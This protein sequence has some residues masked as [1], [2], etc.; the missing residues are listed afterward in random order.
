MAP[1]TPVSDNEQDRQE[2][3]LIRQLISD[4]DALKLAAEASAE[5][6]GLKHEDAIDFEDIGDDDLAEDEDEI[7]ANN[8]F[9]TTQ[10]QENSDNGFNTFG[11]DTDDTTLNAA[12][13][14]DDLFGDA[15]LSPEVE[16]TRL[17]KNG[18]SFEFEGDDSLGEPIGPIQDDDDA[19]FGGDGDEEMLDAP[20]D[21]DNDPD[22]LAGFSKEEREAFQLQRRLFAQAGGVLAMGGTQSLDFFNEAPQ[23]QEEALAQMWPQFQKDEIPRFSELMPFKKAHWIGKKPTRLPKPVQATK[24]K[25]DIAADQEKHFKLSIGPRKRKYDN[26]EEDGLVRI[27]QPELT[28]E[29]D[30]FDDESDF[31]ND[32]IGGVSWQELQTICADWTLLDD[33]DASDFELLDEAD[34]NL[35]SNSYAPGKRRRLSD[36]TSQTQ[37]I[38]NAARMADQSFDNYDR[39]LNKVAKKVVL[40]INDPNLLLV[41]V[42]FDVVPKKAVARTNVKEGQAVPTKELLKRYNI[43]NDGAYEKLKQNHQ[44][45]IRSTLGNLS[46]NHSMPALRLTYPFYKTNLNR[47]ERR[48][49]HRPITTFRKREPITFHDLKFT[50][51]KHQRNKDAK[52]LFATSKDLSLAETSHVLLLE[53]SEEAPTI[54]SNF[55]MNSRL[56]SYYRKR[57]EDDE[58]RPK[59]SLG[60]VSTLMPND[61]SPLTQFGE[62]Q[63]GEIRPTIYNGLFKA[64]VFEH[65]AKAG[66]FLMIRSGTG[67]ET[68]KWHIRPIDNLMVVGQQFPSID[69]PPPGGRKVTT[70]SK[71]R[72]K[73]ISYRLMKRNGPSNGVNISKV[74][75]HVAESSDM[76]NRQKMKDF[77]SFNKET[78]EWEMQGK[79]TVPDEDVIRSYITPEDVC[80]LESMQVGEQRLEDEGYGLE[81]DEALN[82]DEEMKEN[83]AIEEQLAP[84]STSKSFL[85]AASNKAMLQLY[86]EGDPTGRGEAFSFLKISMKGGFRAPNQSIEDTLDA[87]K[88]QESSGHNYNVQKQQEQYRETID[89]IWAAQIRSLS[90]QVEHD[91]P[92]QDPDEEPES[93]RRSM[94]RDRR[95]SFLR[96]PEDETASAWSSASQSSKVCRIVRRERDSTGHIIESVEVI[97]DP[98]VWKRYVDIKNRQRRDK[99]DI[100]NIRPED[101]PELA[102]QKI[103]AELR[104]LLGNKERRFTR[105]KQKAAVSGTAVSPGEPPDAAVATTSTTA[106]APAAT[107]I[108]IPAATATVAAVNVGGAGSSGVVIKGGGATS[109]KCANCGQVGHIKT[110]KKLCPLLNGTM[111][112]ENGGFGEA[113]SAGPPAL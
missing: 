8:G 27:V 11:F 59:V 15:N 40:D 94:N 95:S 82:E 2:N 45:K 44:S 46:L 103:Q 9:G 28:D 98:L 3:D 101:D 88:R 79:A 89:D 77:L 50:K 47:D 24:L 29:S 99:I 12:D 61:T 97:E 58:E 36:I 74:T 22:E 92:E 72:L 83:Q 14:F 76:Q 6:L 75:E 21:D 34:S 65:K 66:D 112:P 30:S 84:W 106:S 56:I 26:M 63:P 87:K 104:R 4:P 48:R 41:P 109:R 67:P 78:K 93:V 54:L 96:R 38:L 81:Q 1:L 111:K 80:L 73:M 23:N 32:T 53:Y 69:I 17:G 70:V 105:E 91:P 5:D 39:L 42:D 43:S 52:E 37:N 16:K 10:T 13:E 31:E 7:S 110:N 85:S 108:A 20:A 102:R 18:T 55:G 107:S 113:F 62:I 86:G 35:Y 25:L 68:S 33:S 64:P 49:L 19:L 90:M 51:K 60:E 57:S 100:R 71:N